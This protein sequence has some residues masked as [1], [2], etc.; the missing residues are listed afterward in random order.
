MRTTLDLIRQRLDRSTLVAYGGWAMLSLLLIIGTFTSLDQAEFTERAAVLDR[1]EAGATAVEQTMLRVFDA[2]NTLQ[3]LAQA[4]L[5]LPDLANQGVRAQAQTK[6]VEQQMQALARDI[7]SNQRFGILQ[8][9]VLSLDGTMDWARSTRG[10]AGWVS[11]PTID[12]QVRDPHAGL[13]I[14]PPELDTATV[15]KRWVVHASRALT[16]TQGHAIAVAVVSL[17]PFA[18]SRLID[19]QTPE[20]SEASVIQLRDSGQIIARSVHPELGLMLKVAATDPVVLAANRSLAEA[21]ACASLKMQAGGQFRDLANGVDRLVG[22]R[23]PCGVPIVVSRSFDTLEALHD[24]YRL[25]GIVLLVVAA[26]IGGAFLATRLFHANFLLRQRLGEQALRDPLTGLNNRR[27]FTDVMG[28]RM[29]QAARAGDTAVVLLVDL[30]GFKQ[31]NDTRGHAV[32]DALLKDVARRLRDCTSDDDTVIRL[33]GDEFA[34]VRVGRP[35]RRD[36]T[37]LAR[38]IVNE[39]SETYEVDRYH[40]RVS[41]SVG[42]AMPPDGGEDLNDLLRSADIA[43]YFA[44]SEGGAAYQLF[45]PAMENSVRTRRALEIDLREALGRHELEVFFQPLVQ[46]DPYRVS[47]FEALLRWHHPTLGMVMPSRFIPVAEETGLIAPIGEWVLR[48]ACLEAARWPAGTRVAVNLS[49]LQFER[50]DIVDI[51]AAA[52][53]E[54]HLEPER[55]ELEI[56]EGVVMRD[57]GDVLATMRKLRNL[58]VRLALDDFGTG[59]SSLSYLRSFP[60]DKVKIDGS[61]LADLAGDGGTII[62]AVLGLCR[63]LDLDMLVE[64]VET[65]D[66]LD[67]LRREGCIEV[68]GH[69]FSPPR[70]ANCVTDIIADVIDRVPEAETLGANGAAD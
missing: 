59:Y 3:D 49:P 40:L 39:L 25:R 14:S 37:A 13:I 28:R 36:V 10:A 52:L 5:R 1:A 2:V 19:F 70:P 23:A 55:L 4:R 41:A 44:K 30:D 62:R 65:Q 58:G 69:L 51:V 22:Y 60:F 31:V 12:D 64:G 38:F 46:L 34:V 61:F 11:E 7:T 24:F 9:S 66:Q 20:P 18:L 15:P 27:Y 63:H 42:V 45:D 35:Q 43:M 50:S 47:G 48:E 21:G 33:G 8:I 26:L 68:Q 53:R 6:A 54:S 67:W 16:D 57:S 32:G 17:D 29:V 56:T